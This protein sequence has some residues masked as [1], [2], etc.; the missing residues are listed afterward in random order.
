[1]C[2]EEEARGIRTVGGK[3]GSDSLERSRQYRR[4]VV[5]NIKNRRDP[6]AGRKDGEGGK[7]CGLSTNKGSIKYTWK[8]RVKGVKKARR[9][10]TIRGKATHE[11]RERRKRAR[12]KTTTKYDLVHHRT[13]KE[14]PERARSSAFHARNGRKTWGI[15]EQKPGKGSSRSR[16]TALRADER[17]RIALDTSTVYGK[18]KSQKEETSAAASITKMTEEHD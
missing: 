8:W 7:Y 5:Q 2:E 15:P 1:M 3:G 13:Q 6:V 10:N 12:I 18:R 17:Q 9:R 16:G 14:R 11:G 4:R